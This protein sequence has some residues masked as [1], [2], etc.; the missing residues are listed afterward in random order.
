TSIGILLLAFSGMNLFDAVNYA[1]SAISTTGMDTT[2]AGLTKPHSWLID[3][4]LIII[5]I[6]GAIPFYVHYIFIR[7]RNFVRAIKDVELKALIALIFFFFILLTPHFAYAFGSL[8]VNAELNALF[9][10]VSASTGGGF[11]LVKEEQLAM[12]SDFAKFILVIAMFIGG[13]AGSTAGGIKVA[14]FV[15]LMKSLFWRAKKL[16]LPKGSMFAKR[17]EGRTLEDSEIRAI[18]QFILL[19]TLFI[20]VG[21]VVLLECGYELSNSL[22]EVVSAQSNVGISVGITSAT[23]PLVAKIMLIINMLIGRLEILPLFAV[24]GSL[25]LVRQEE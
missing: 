1:F 5:M 11:S 13:G 7:K 22:F 12:L 24:I 9:H 23:M 19:Y 4:S 14:R 10:V 15:I 16:I 8:D 6:L 21:T 17:F 20:V 3:I 2:T 25:L 18:Y